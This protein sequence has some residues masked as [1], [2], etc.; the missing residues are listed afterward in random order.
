MKLRLTAALCMALMLSA[1][2]SDNAETGSGTVSNP[3]PSSSPD[4]NPNPAP[5]PS[6]DPE[7]AP[8]PDPAP[9]PEPTPEPNPD[10]GDST[11]PAPTDV[12]VPLGQPVS[13]VIGP[14]GGYLSFPDGAIRLYV[15]EGAFATEQ[16][17]AIQE[18]TNLAHGAKGRAFRIRPEG[19]HTS[20]PMTLSFQY[21]DAELAG[22][23]LEYLRI[24]YQSPAKIWHVYTNPTIDTFD[25]TLSVQTYHFS[26]WSLIAGV[27]LMPRSARVQTGG[28]IELQVVDCQRINTDTVDENGE[29]VVPSMPECMPSP[30]DA[31]ETRDWSVNGTVGGSVQFGTIV[32]NADRF[33]GKAT[34]TAPVTKP[35][36][37]VVAVSVKHT[38]DTGDPE[39]V[40]L[41]VSNITIEDTATACL[42]LR[43]VERFH[44]ELS[45]DAFSFTQTAENR[46]YRGNHSGHLVGTLKKIFANT[47]NVG[48]D[49]WMTT[50][51]PVTGHVSISD[52]DV[53]TPPGGN[54]HN[55][56]F[57]FNG[58]PYDGADVAS[59]IML[60]L[61][62]ATCTFDLIGAFVARGT[63]YSN[64]APIPDATSGSGVVMFGLPL[65]SGES[66]DPRTLEG[67]LALNVVS[68]NQQTGFVPPDSTAFTSRS[69]NTTARWSITPLSD[70]ED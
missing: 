48:F 35:E 60:K 54:G 31:Y 62:H 23:A 32:A 51:N 59:Y 17:V 12:G 20:V 64:G 52:T 43:D 18:I 49:V 15:P 37:N 28:Q 66:S 57:D 40:R 26:D 42:A 70:E 39:P 9:D 63:G 8:D 29:L 25:R 44:A 2:G 45:F 41:L 33:S 14:D 21:T 34:Y 27:Q 3:P 19:L 6:P 13:A 24:A 30:L 55:N 53:F 65:S 7:P 38:L 50:H 10:E 1:C 46:I 16:T 58:P 4:P 47:G 11:P 36:N 68:D 61:D 56:S 22:T 5:D 69:G 67:S